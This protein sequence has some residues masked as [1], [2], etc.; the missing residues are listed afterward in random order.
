LILDCRIDGRKVSRLGLVGLVMLAGLAV[1]KAR[2]QA[3]WSPTT[4]AP[5]AEAPVFKY[6]VW[7][8]VRSP[9]A[10]S[11]GANPDLIELL[12]AGG[13]PNQEA[14]LRRVVL[15]KAVNRK[16]VRLNVE[17]LMAKGDVV[18]LSP[19]DVVIV[20]RSAWYTIRDEFWIVTT[21]AVLVNL[22]LTIYAMTGGGE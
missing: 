4:A 12:S 8:E 2:A 5:K 1:S 7:G 20:P 11:L 10:Y 19:G 18:P 6:Y 14:N 17:R 22:G 3:T 13:G 15:V 21:A 9:G 16:R